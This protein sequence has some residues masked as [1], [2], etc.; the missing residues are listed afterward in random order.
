M[1]KV[2]KVLF[3]LLLSVCTI[4]GIVACD[5]KQPET[6]LADTAKSYVK[7]LYINDPVETAA[8]YN[9][10]AKVDIQGTVYEVLWTVNV[11]SGEPND[12]KLVKSEDGSHYVVDLNNFAEVATEYTLT[13]T[14]KGTNK[15]ISFEHKI[16]VFKFTTYEE[17]LEKCKSGSADTL[18]IKGYVIAV[19]GS[20]SSAGSIYLQDDDGHGYYAYA[21]KNS[22]TYEM[23]EEIIV[24]GTGTVYGGQYEFNKGCSVEKTGI[25]VDSLP[26]QDATADFA[27]ATSQKDDRLIKY[28]NALVKITGNTM[29]NIDGLYYYF[30]VG[31]SQVKFNLYDS[32]YFLPA[33]VRKAMTDQ[34]EAGKTFDIYGLVSCYSNLY[35]IYPVIPETLQ[36]VGLP[37]KSDAEAVATVKE[38]LQIPQV[39]FEQSGEMEV[40]IKGYGDQV[41]ITWTSDNPLVTID[42][43]GKV[44]VT[45][46]EEALTVKLTATL[47]AG[48]VTDT[49]VFTI[50]VDALATDQYLPVFIDEVKTGSFVIAMDRTAQAQLG[51]KVMYADG[52]L[53]SKGALVM[54]EKATN[55][56]TFTIAAVDGKTGVYTIKVNG[57]YLVAYRNGTYNNMKLA[58]EPGE[59]KWDEEL[60]TFVA[61]ITYDSKTITVYFGS[62]AKVTND[63]ATELTDGFALSE[64]KYVKGENAV[65]VGVTQFVGQLGTVTLKGIEFVAATEPKVG[66]F[67]I[68]MDRTAQAQLGGKVMY[69]DGT[70]NSKGALV[71][72]EKATNA[73][74]F[75]IA[76]VDGKTGVYTIKVNG[77]YLVAYRNG[78]YNNMKLA[79]E[80]GEWKWDEELKTFVADITYD[81]KTIT[82]YFGSYAKVTNDIA[83][84]LTDG[85]ALSETKYVKGE[86][87]VK[88]GVTQ[89]VGQLG[90]VTLKGIE[91]VAATEPKVGSFVIAMDRTAQAQLG[92]KVM[93][94]D[95]TLNSKGALVMTEKAT[96]AATFTIAAVDGKT[97]VYTIKVNG[98]YLVAYRNGTYNNMKLAD[99]PGEWKWDEEL[100]TFV[101]DITYDSKTITVYF[102]SYAKVTNDIATELTDGFALSETKYVKG[103]NAVKVGVTQ[104]VGQLGTIDFVK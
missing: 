3:C 9:V 52:T 101:A 91:F 89:F 8:D 21:P 31:E 97:G 20:G 46:S 65:K 86:N 59:W 83:T 58:D 47:V 26:F 13:A 24:R 90:T 64:T 84:E 104:F 23:G 28:Q 67:V 96:N 99:E 85:F 7:T 11:K 71:M 10:V 27:A 15:S 53:N 100:K 92:G 38:N 22:G 14:I 5:V 40:S 70:L 42:A 98:K 32:Y 55:A 78:T 54:T 45:Q 63:I 16:P 76:A 51:G 49:K 1:K 79:D 82:V 30:T 37:T 60:K 50:T 34:W 80:P 102:G 2:L 43:A 74:T 94:A 18:V 95:G 77:K 17:W 62:Y 72:T 61:D 33:D 41:A 25:K 48:T 103:E 66:S 57:K 69:A 75:T 29:S 19:V 87:A 93:Y 12:I 39:K 6:D 81:S 56:A 44:T 73:A 88:V 36:N 68:A 4:S 35:Q